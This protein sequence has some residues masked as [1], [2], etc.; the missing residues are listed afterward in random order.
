MCLHSAFHFYPNLQKSFNSRYPFL[1]G[2]IDINYLQDPGR[3][4]HHVFGQEGAYLPGG[5]RSLPAEVAGDDR[6]TPP[7]APP[8][9]HSRPSSRPARAWSTSTAQCRHS[10]VYPAR[11]LLCR[12]SSSLTKCMLKPWQ[13]KCFLF[14][15]H[16]TDKRNKYSTNSTS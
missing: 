2:K 3:F 8:P 11:A 10:N 6:G 13:N 9:W 15:E 1:S 12:C 4:V 7:V 16:F 14:T 5:L